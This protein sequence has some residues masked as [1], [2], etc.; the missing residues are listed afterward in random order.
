MKE[1][2]SD[3][4]NLTEEFSEKTTDGKEPQI[5]SKFKND[6]FAWIMLSEIKP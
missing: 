5:I 1:E 6:E 4:K 2:I 3:K